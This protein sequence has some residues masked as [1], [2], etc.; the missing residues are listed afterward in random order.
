MGLYV[1]PSFPGGEAVNPHPRTQELKEEPHKG[2]KPRG[3]SLKS[4]MSG[5][6]HSTWQPG[7]RDTGPDPPAFQRGRWA[8]VQKV[9]S[10]LAP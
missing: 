2:A 8:S 5:C 3:L 6:R 7:C 10:L 9:P 1:Q 4:W